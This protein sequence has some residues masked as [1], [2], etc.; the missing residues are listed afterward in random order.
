MNGKVNIIYLK[1]T[2]K[3]FYFLI[4]LV[5]AVHRWPISVLQQFKIVFIFQYSTVVFICKP[6]NF[7]FCFSTFCAD[8]DDPLTF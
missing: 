8:S 7:T 5:W 3:K 1:T 4:W 2:K 6:L